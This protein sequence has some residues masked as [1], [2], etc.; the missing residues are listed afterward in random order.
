MGSLGTNPDLNFQQWRSV[1]GDI[2]Y[3]GLAFAERLV[4]IGARR[5]LDATREELLST[6]VGGYVT[7]GVSAYERVA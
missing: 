4:D 2:A 7:T 5:E 1:E 6:P 3:D